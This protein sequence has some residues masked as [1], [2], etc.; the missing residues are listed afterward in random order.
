TFTLQE[1]DTAGNL[2]V[3]TFTLSIA[4]FALESAALPDA[5]VGVAYAR[6]LVTFGPSPLTWTPVT[7]PPGLTLSSSG[8]LSGTPP[9]AGTFTSPAIGTDGAVPVTFNSPLRVSGIS[10]GDTPILP[11]AVVGQPYTYAFSGSGGGA[12]KVWTATGLPGGL[13]MST[14]GVISGT[15][16]G[17][18]NGG[19]IF[20]VTI[21]VND[22]GVPLTA[23]FSLPVENPNLNVF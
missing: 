6:P 8:L 19:S 10:I 3:R 7:V 5:S 12:T 1:Q 20:G 14:A 2:G 23:R 11:A 16:T 17:A 4:D 15:I 9:F 22:G 21:T 13:T 18:G